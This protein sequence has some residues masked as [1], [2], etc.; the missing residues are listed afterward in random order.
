MDSGLRCSAWS[1]WVG[2]GAGGG[3]RLAALA[4]LAPTAAAAAAAAMAGSLATRAVVM[5]TGHTIGLSTGASVCHQTGCGDSMRPCK[6]RVG[7]GEE[8]L[9]Y[10]LQAPILLQVL[11]GGYR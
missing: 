1:F 10:R 6:K 3:A 4:A 5:Q 9:I 2:G 11:A 7:E 8:E